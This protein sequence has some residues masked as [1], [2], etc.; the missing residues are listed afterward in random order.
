MKTLTFRCLFVALLFTLAM[1]SHSTR[2]YE[3]TF[4]KKSQ[5]GKAIKV[6]R[7]DEVTTWTG[8]ITG[9]DYGDTNTFNYEF[10]IEP[11]DSEWKGS[12]NQVPLALVFCDNETFL[13]VADRIVNYD[14]LYGPPTFKDT[15]LYFR[16]VDERYFFK[17]FGEQY[18]VDSDSVAYLE[19]KAKCNE[20]A[21]PVK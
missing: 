5:N 17:M 3:R 20:V 15:T 18:F 7:K 19:S 13:K 9:K 1:C 2:H 6:T 8:M 16:N 4:Q 12:V 14:S 11:D 10:N 21:V